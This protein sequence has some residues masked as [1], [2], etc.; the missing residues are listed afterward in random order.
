MSALNSKLERLSLG[1]LSLVANCISS[2][3]EYLT[4]YPKVKGSSAATV[5]SF[6]KEMGRKSP[7]MAK[8][9]GTVVEHLPRHSKVE[10]SSSAP[11]TDTGGECY[12]TFLSVIYAFFY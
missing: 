6:S 10:G 5:H 8:C 1:K 12:K 4:H 9:I 2:E 3:V 11:A 7:V